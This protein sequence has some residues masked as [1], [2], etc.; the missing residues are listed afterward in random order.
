MIT[1][2]DILTK[3]DRVVTSTP[4]GQKITAH[5]I[6][7]LRRASDDTIDYI[8][9]VGSGLGA[10]DIR[11]VG[12]RSDFPEPSNG[13][14]TLADNAT[15]VIVG[16][17]DLDGDRLVCGDS[18]TLIGTSS[19]TSTLRSTGLSEALI[20]SQYSLA[21]RHLTI[22]SAVALDLSGA[23]GD[24][25]ALDWTGV[26][27]LNCPT[28]GTIDGTANFTY[29]NG[30][31]LGSGNLTLT[32]SIGTVAFNQCLLAPAAGQTAII[33]PDTLAISRRLRI[34]YSSFVVPD[35][36]TGI[37]LSASAAIPVEGYILDT[38][39]FAGA[40]TYIAG[41]Q[42]DDDKSRFLQCRG[43]VNTT[44]II[45]VF[46]AGNSTE[47]VVSDAGDRYPVAGTSDTCSIIQRFTL[48]QDGNA[49]QYDSTISRTFKAQASL[50]LTAPQNN[51]IGVGIGVARSGAA[52]DPDEDIVE[53][54][55][56]QVTANGSRPDAAFVQALVQLEQNDRIYCVVQN[57]GATGNITVNFLN[58]IITEQA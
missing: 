51:I 32:G 23:G 3:S 37:D 22:T 49:A 45:N 16:D 17:V 36:S 12:S 2:S 41:V 5:D 46:M 7:E 10:G 53:Q 15:Y 8:I 1:K 13:V 25:V 9:G 52:L 18:T 43:I 19:E 14:I 48:I 29:F 24:N 56:V 39:N 33:A 28:I 21:M 26:N 31:L 20:T 57:T 50:S 6:N 44:S 34:I 55:E 38:V 47:T 58:L 35:T 11:F 4:A 27:F 30:A 40:G 54:S 42:A